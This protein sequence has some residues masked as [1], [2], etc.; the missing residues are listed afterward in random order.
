MLLFYS[1]VVF[2]NSTAQEI[3]GSYA[4]F[5]STAFLNKYLHDSGVDTNDNLKVI[6]ID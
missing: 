4:S 3:A 1:A 2:V 6:Y 5:L